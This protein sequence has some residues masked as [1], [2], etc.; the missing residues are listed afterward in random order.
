MPQISKS[1]AALRIIGESVQPDEI[2]KQLGCNPTFSCRKGDT[3]HT[4]NKEIRSIYR[5]GMW[6]FD[7][8]D[9][10]PEN[11]DK[12]VYYIINRVS[13]DIEVW[14]MLREQYNIDIICTLSMESYNEGMELSP[15]SML[16]LGKRG[17]TLGLD[18]YS[19]YD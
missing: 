12:Q 18:I 14:N 4:K 1:T 9:E 3:R 19:P 8:K 7:A 15:G 11:L 13:S 16:A 5:Q 17:I 6:R 10:S 2:T